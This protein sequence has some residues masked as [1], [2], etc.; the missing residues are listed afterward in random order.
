MS[1]KSAKSA[2]SSKKEILERNIKRKNTAIISMIH[3]TLMLVVL[4]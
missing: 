1:S 3:L 2:K 4:I